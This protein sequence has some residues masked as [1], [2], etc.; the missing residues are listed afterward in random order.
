M[1]VVSRKGFQADLQGDSRDA[2]ER[3]RKHHEMP[4]KRS[5]PSSFLTW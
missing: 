1:D 4:L 2:W 5:S 3:T